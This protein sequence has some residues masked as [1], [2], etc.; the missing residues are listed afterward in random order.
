MISAGLPVLQHCQSAQCWT[1][2]APASPRLRPAAR[3]PAW[4]QVMARGPLVAALLPVLMAVLTS[5]SLAAARRTIPPSTAENNAASASCGSVPTSCS[6]NC[7]AAIHAALSAC[8][9]SGGGTVSLQP[10]VYHVDDPHD[11]PIALTGLS[12]VALVGAAGTGGFNTDG[13]DPTATTLMLHGIRQAFSVSN[14]ARVAFRGIQ[15]DMERQPYTYGQ[16]VAVAPDSFVL[17]FDPALYPF[18][19]PVPS[20]M[21]KVQA[22]MGFDPSTWR[23]AQDAVDIYATSDPLNCSLSAPGR[24]SVQG[25]GS[26]SSKHVKVGDW[27]VLRHQVYAFNAFNFANVTAPTL[28]D[29]TVWSVPG[30]GFYFS[31]STDISIRNCGVRARPGRPMSI[32]ARP[33]QN[34]RPALC[35]AHS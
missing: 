3:A 19:A 5:L 6:P 26:G 23:M 2:S 24:L 17:E 9:A 21:T 10:G 14:S 8:S 18:P 33:E 13:A 29:I 30:M 16:C 28:V 25:A 35:G 34:P 27:Y 31:K 11:A 15:I 22:V 7:G 4:G 20:W 1:A 32:T 12:D